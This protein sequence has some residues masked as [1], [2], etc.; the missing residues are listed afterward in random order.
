MEKTNTIITSTLSIGLIGLVVGIGLGYAF[1]MTRY[2][3][4]GRGT[5]MMSNGM[6]MQG[7]RM[8][9]MHGE[10]QGMVG[11]LE[12]KTGD[13]FDRAFLEEMII[14]HEGA[15]AMAEMLL[16]NTER[17]ELRK[18]GEDI[19]AA[20]TGEIGMMRGWLRDWYGN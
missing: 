15:V 13:E 14:H 8:S 19:I 11:A 10:M 17:Q 5:H 6:M 9:G 18:L 4:P 16:A 7:E 20:Q 1:G 12:G 3:I 2:G